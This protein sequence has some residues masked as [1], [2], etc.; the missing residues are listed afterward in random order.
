[1]TTL[2]FVG[3][4]VSWGLDQY[5]FTGQGNDLSLKREAAVVDATGFGSRFE[6]SLAGIQKASMD[7]KG[8]W[9][10]EQSLDQVINLKFGQDP[11]VLSW[12]APKGLTAL[13]PLV[14]MPSVITKFDVDAKLKEDVGFDMSLMARNYVDVGNILVSPNV[15]TT[16]TGTSGVVDSTLTTGVT[17]AGGSGQLHIWSVTGTT[18][19]VVMK[20]QHS[21]DGTTWTDLITFTTATA[22]TSQRTVLPRQTVVNQQIRASWTITG[23]TPSFIMLVGFSRGVVYL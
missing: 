8:H 20:I 5:D 16:V 18:P 4:N 15:F 11:D 13:N 3:R 10:A 9:A 2:A 6:N 1:M 21:P 23:T 12:F 14:M 19:S 7:V 17:A 22:A